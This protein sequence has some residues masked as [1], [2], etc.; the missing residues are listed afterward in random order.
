MLAQHAAMLCLGIA[1]SLLYSLREGLHSSS[2]NRRSMA[3]EAT[4]T[5]GTCRLRRRR[6]WAEHRAPCRSLWPPSRVGG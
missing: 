2:A 6:H 4:G 5:H 1:I 3:W